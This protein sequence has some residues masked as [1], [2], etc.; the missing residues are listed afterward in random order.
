MILRNVSRLHSV[1]SRNHR[2]DDLK[3]CY[4]F[5]L[6]FYYFLS[7]SYSLFLHSGCTVFCFV[8]LLVIVFPFPYF[9]VFVSSFLQTQYLQGPTRPQCTY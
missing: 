6:I 5:L 7:S 1:I 2:C 8:L 4:S 3:F 9:A